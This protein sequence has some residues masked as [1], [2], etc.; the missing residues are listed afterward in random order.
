MAWRGLG[1]TPAEGDGD[2]GGPMEDLQDSL[3][4]ALYWSLAFSVI[5]LPVGYATGLWVWVILGYAAIICVS[6]IVGVVQ[7]VG[8]RVLTVAALLLWL[9][10]LGVGVCLVAFGVH[11]IVTFEPYC[12]PSEMVDCRLLLNGQD[13]GEASVADQRRSMVTD[14]LVPI[15]GGAVIAVAALVFGAARVRDR[16]PQARY[17]F[18]RQ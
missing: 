12:T 7:A 10:V 3:R 1:S 16:A 14:S 17:L 4:N 9:L 8:G 18:R 5:L 15:G 6:V 11:A 13:V 2:D